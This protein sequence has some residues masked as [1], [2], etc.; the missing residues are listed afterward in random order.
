[1][2]KK[3][4]VIDLSTFTYEQLVERLEELT[5]EMS[6]SSVG[7][8]TVSSLYEEAE[9]VKVEAELRIAK[10]REQVEKLTAPATDG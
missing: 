8:E 9:C 10:V 5:N 6:G 4:D 1:M 3:S 2:V 7:I